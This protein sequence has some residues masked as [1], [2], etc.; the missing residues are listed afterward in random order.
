MLIRVQNDPFDQS[1]GWLVSE[2]HDI[3]G[4]DKPNHP[5]ITFINFSKLTVTPA[6]NETSVVMGFYTISLKNQVPGAL[7]YGRGTYDFQEGS[8]SFVAPEQVITF[9]HDPDAEEIVSISFISLSKVG[10]VDVQ[11]DIFPSVFNIED[12]WQP[13][14][15]A[16][17]RRADFFVG[18]L[19]HGGV[20]GGD[21]RTGAGEI[22]VPPQGDGRVAIGVA[23]DKR[24]NAIFVAGGGDF[25]GISAAY[26]YDAETGNQLAKYM[27]N[28]GLI[29]DVVVTHDAAYFTDSFNPV[30]FRIPLGPGGE[31]PDPSDPEA[32]QEIP[33]G[34]GFDFDPDAF[35]NANGIE[36]TP[37]GKWLI[38]ANTEFG[39]LYR[40]DPLTGEAIRIDL[41]DAEVPL[42]GAD[43][44]V[45]A[46]RTM[47]VA[48]GGENEIGV[49][50]LDPSL[51]S[52]V[53]SDTPL[54][55]PD[56]QVPT[57]AAK[58]GSTIYAVNARFGEFDFG[59]PSP[60][61]EFTGG[62]LTHSLG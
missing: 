18:S 20:Y 32:V 55:S 46:G 5:L 51:T 49:V 11:A 7:K 60:N 43:G 52:G 36:A 22:I 61:L 37:N 29:N 35:V 50:T 54:T 44:L 33:L 48:Q 39:S 47:Y 21:L 24:T 6:S 25:L 40:V 27:L 59:V 45:L 10:S 13:E 56:F 9:R 14:G 58:F 4:Y 34:D 19:L 28:D 30:L 57:T 17:G 62:G 31:L 12:G 2:L 42:P 15:I 38:I 8:L 1:V 16:I 26:V 3:I 41:G 23:V 53:V